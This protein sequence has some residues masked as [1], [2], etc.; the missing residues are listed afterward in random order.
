VTQVADRSAAAAEHA[1]AGEE[2][3]RLARDLHD[4]TAHTIAVIAVQASVAEEALADGPEPA[5]AAVQAI[6]AASRQALT[7]LKA[8]VGALREG[9]GIAERGPLPGLGRLGELVA[10]AQGAGLR[11]ELA[12]AGPARPLGPV[13]ELTAYRIV[14]E[15][16][17]NVL[18][19][20]QATSAAVRVCYPPDG[21]EVEVTDDGQG[22]G[23]ARPGWSGSDGGPVA[24]RGHGLAVMAE[25]AAA[26]G[27]RLEAGPR[28]AGG[29]RVHARLPQGE[30]AAPRL[31]RPLDEAPRSLG[32][33]LDEASRSLG[34]PPPTRPP[35]GNR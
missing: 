19:H 8:T 28:P 29:F 6:R 3:L 18:R 30:G 5:R 22:A 31:G 17:T 9:S 14:Q 2:R 21:V 11:V 12:V 15:A 32:R 10:M 20:A 24:S 25:R 4:I 26:V 7:E 16:L 23:P 33:P 35:S 34:R 1:V 27:G 13:V